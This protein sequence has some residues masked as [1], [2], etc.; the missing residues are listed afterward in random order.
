MANPTV[1]Q[2]Y[3]RL[4]TRSQLET[5]LSNALADHAAGVTITST[6]FGDGQTSGVISGKPEEIIAILE[7]A[8][9]VLDGTTATNAPLAAA[10]GFSLRRVE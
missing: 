5:A 8:L 3:L 4:Y 10:V 1:V 7:T 6:S 9:Q 2:A